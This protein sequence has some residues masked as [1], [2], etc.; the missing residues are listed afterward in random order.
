MGTSASELAAFDIV[1]K[2]Q[3]S[4]PD[5][6]RVML[7]HL[8]ADRFALKVHTAETEMT[9]FVVG[10]DPKGLKMTASKDANAP[11]VSGQREL[12]VKN[13][14]IELI[15]DKCSMPLG[16]PL[17]DN[18]GL[19]NRQFD[20]TFAITWRTPDEVAAGIISGLRGL[21]LIASKQKR[22]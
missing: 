1:A 5:E 18:T 8:L 3:S 6:M 17:I 16:A 10:I 20:G 13:A 9:V 14:T 2:S 22:L 12:E 19:G 21:G 11:Q 15:L 7:Q 4:N